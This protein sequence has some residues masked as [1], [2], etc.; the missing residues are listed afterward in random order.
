MQP[1][2][3]GHRGAARLAPENTLRAFRAGVDAGAEGAAGAAPLSCR[4]VIVQVP[5][6]FSLPLPL[7]VM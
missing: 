2:I 7:Q 5:P 4:T 1:K 6:H 3:V